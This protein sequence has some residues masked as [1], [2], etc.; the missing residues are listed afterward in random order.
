MNTYRVEF[1]LGRYVLVEAESINE[2]KDYLNGMLPFYK[3]KSIKQEVVHCVKQ[4]V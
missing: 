3:V 1:E 4:D 2:V